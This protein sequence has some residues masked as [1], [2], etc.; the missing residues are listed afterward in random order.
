[1]ISI[2]LR[3]DPKKFREKHNQGWMELLKIL[4]STIFDR[5]S[6]RRLTCLHPQQFQSCV[7]KEHL[8]PW[9]DTLFFLL[10]SVNP[11]MNL[12]AHFNPPLSAEVDSGSQAAEHVSQGQNGKPGQLWGLCLSHTGLCHPFS[13]NLHSSNSV[14]G[15]PFLYI[16]ANTC[17]F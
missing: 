12:Q 11:D 2:D 14:G 9:S 6:D 17:Y 13:T 3:L 10:D 1:M 15:L 5:V 16:L 7:P 4:G 8:C